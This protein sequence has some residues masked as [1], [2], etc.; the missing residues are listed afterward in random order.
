MLICSQK[1][2]FQRATELE[3]PPTFDDRKRNRLRGSNPG[4]R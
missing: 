1:Y 4:S 3:V 2:R